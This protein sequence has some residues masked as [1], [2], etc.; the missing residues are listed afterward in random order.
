MQNNVKLKPSCIAIKIGIEKNFIHQFMTRNLSY[1]SIRLLGTCVLFRTHSISKV[2]FF[3][4]TN[5]DAIIFKL[6]FIYRGG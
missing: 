5:Y 1:A 3:C 6:I 2:R 4:E